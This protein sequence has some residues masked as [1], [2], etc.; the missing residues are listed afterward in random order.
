M[1]GEQLHLRLRAR[2][3]KGV[4]RA[5]RA[6]LLVEYNEQ[7]SSNA[8]QCD[9]WYRVVTRARRE[10][11]RSIVGELRLGQGRHIAPSVLR[12][13]SGAMDSPCSVFLVK[14]GESSSPVH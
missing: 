4:E 7:C 5:K 8:M 3:I 11:F 12:E 10:K 2:G 13:E 6:S 1:V 9:D 14:I